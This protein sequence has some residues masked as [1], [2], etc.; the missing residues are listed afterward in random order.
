MQIVIRRSE[1]FDRG[2]RRVLDGCYRDDAGPLRDAVD[3][4]GT[5]AALPDSATIFGARHVQVVAKHPEQGRRLIAVESS[6]F[7]VYRE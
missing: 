6:D 2:N 1:T 4:H 5:R 3:M 7:F